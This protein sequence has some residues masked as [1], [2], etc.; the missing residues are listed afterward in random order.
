MLCGGT[1]SV[2]I[3][4]VWRLW[5]CLGGFGFALYFPRTVPC[6]WFCDF[7]VFVFGVLAFHCLCTVLLLVIVVK[8]RENRKENLFFPLI[9]QTACRRVTALHIIG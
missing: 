2:D 1:F 3:A 7:V 4:G 5:H 6:S 9:S 8:Y